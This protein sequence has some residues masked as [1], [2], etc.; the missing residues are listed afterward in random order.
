MKNYF[1]MKFFESI[2]LNPRMEEL[3]NI[4]FL[5]YNLAEYFIEI[6]IIQEMLEPI[7]DKI[8]DLERKKL[9]TNIQKILTETDLVRKIKLI[10]NNKFVKSIKGELQ[11]INTI[12]NWF[13]HPRVYINDIQ[14]LNDNPKVL[15]SKNDNFR[16]LMISMNEYMVENASETDQRELERSKEMLTR[17]KDEIKRNLV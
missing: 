17:L 16:K 8:D 9:S 7:E 15:K 13:S 10:K 3:R 2:S 11:S 1:D 5:A 4:V 12:R 14:E 6:I